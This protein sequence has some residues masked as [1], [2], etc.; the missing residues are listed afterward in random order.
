M[1]KFDKFIPNLRFTYES[2][3]RD[4]SFLDLMATLSEQK[5]KTKYI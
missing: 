1:K 3:E 2:N 5:W 4:I